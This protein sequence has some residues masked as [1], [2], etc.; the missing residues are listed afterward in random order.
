MTKF[1]IKKL[2]DVAQYKAECEVS[3]WVI[4]TSALLQ[5]ARDD[6]EIPHCVTFD[7]PEVNGKWYIILT[8]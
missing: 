4:A 1:D 7:F 6:G 3:D 8:C 5:Q 2:Q